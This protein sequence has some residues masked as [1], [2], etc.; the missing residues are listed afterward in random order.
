[1]KQLGFLF[2]LGVVFG[3]VGIGRAEPTFIAARLTLTTEA[4][5]LPDP[6]QYFVSDRYSTGAF[7][8]Q[9]ASSSASSSTGNGTAI[10]QASAHTYWQSNAR[11]RVVFD[12]VAFV[13]AILHPSGMAD[14]NNSIWYYTF[15]NEDENV[16]KLHY[17]IGIKDSTD[18]IVGIRGFSFEVDENG[19][20][21]Y[22]Q[23]LDLND[24]GTIVVPLDPY[25]T[26]TVKVIPNGSFQ[27][28]S[29]LGI[30]SMWGNFSWTIKHVK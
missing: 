6:V 3:S 16:F 21:I 5:V 24:S 7:A 12:N 29:G 23:D 28:D 2:A 13:Q 19:Q 30:S 20:T 1:M 26:Y 8:D 10:A 22:A 14:V 9:T 18:E 11:G 27:E 15:V 17:D 4:Q 25:Q